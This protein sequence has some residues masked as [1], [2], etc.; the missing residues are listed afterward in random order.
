[1]PNGFHAALP[2]AHANICRLS[3]SIQI[4]FRLVAVDYL[5]HS[6]PQKSRPEPQRDRD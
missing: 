6:G 5:S 1:M 2:K 3:R 4:G